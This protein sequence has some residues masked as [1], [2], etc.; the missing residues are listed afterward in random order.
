MNKFVYFMAVGLA[1][2]A[3]QVATVEASHDRAHVDEMRAMEDQTRQTMRETE[4]S[5][6]QTMRETEDQTRQTM[7]ETEDSE[8]QAARD[9][10]DT[11]LQVAEEAMNTAAGGGDGGPDCEAMGAPG[12]AARTACEVGEGGH[13]DCSEIPDAAGRALCETAEARG[14]PPTAA[15][16]ALVGDPAECLRHAAGG[17]HGD[18]T[19]TDPCMGITP[20]ADQDACYAQQSETSGLDC[21]DPTNATMAEC[22]TP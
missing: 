19:G 18:H 17:G 4:D 14:T 16:C 1:F 10:E 6:R 15:E 20:Q 21:N 3:L 2:T 7:R 8:R 9:A 22:T 5:A 11:A 12:S 13:H